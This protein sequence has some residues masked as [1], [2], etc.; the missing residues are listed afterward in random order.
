M[1]TAHPGWTNVMTGISRLPPKMC[2]CR[3]RRDVSEFKLLITQ[4]Q[5][6]TAWMK[7]S[8]QKFT[9]QADLFV[10][11]CAEIFPATKA[12]VLPPKHRRFIRC[13]VVPRCV[14]DVM[15]QL[16]FL[17]AQYVF[18]TESSFNGEEQNRNIREVYVV[19]AKAIEVRNCLE[20]WRVLEKRFPM[21]TFPGHILTIF[22]RILQRG[23]C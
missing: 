17:Y 7:D 11:A 10:D 6:N 1:N 18:S 12:C 19:A 23:S 16:I 14:T 22:A 20:L 5:N 2:V 8:V 3:V 4:E 13:D 21:K 9:K 15:P